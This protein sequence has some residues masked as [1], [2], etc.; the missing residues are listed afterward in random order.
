VTP[1]NR[2]YVN[3]PHNAPFLDVLRSTSLEE[4]CVDQPD[5]SQYRLLFEVPSIFRLLRPSEQAPVDRFR[6]DVTLNR[7][8]YIGA[9]LESVGRW[10]HVQL[11]I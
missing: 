6:Q 4:V 1:D 2:L 10:F 7:F 11:N 5:V 9:R 8:H 3:L